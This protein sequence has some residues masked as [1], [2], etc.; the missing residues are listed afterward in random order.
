MRAFLP[1][2]GIDE[3]YSERFACPEHGTFLEEL[4]PRVF[5]FN[6]PYGACAHCCGLGHLQQF[7][8]DLVVP[9]ETLSSI[10]ERRHRALDRARVRRRQGL[11][12]GPP[13]RHRRA[14]RRR[15][16]H[17][18]ARS[19]ARRSGDTVLHGTEDAIEVVYSRGGRETMRFQA[20]FEGVIPNLDRRLREAQ[21]E[22]A[23]EKL[24][25]YMSLVPCPQCHGSRYKPEVL[26]VRVAGRNI[27]DVSNLTVVDARAFFRD[28]TL[29]GAAGDVARPDPARGQRPPRLPRGRRP[30]LPLARPQRQHALRRRGAAHPARDP[31]R[32]RPDGRALRPRRALDRPAP[33]RQRP[34]AADPAR[35]CATS[36]TRSSSSSTTR[37]RCGPRT[38]SWTSARARACTAARWS[39]PAPP[40]ELLA[41]PGLAHRRATCGASCASRCPS[42]DA[43]ATARR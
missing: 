27:A 33:A 13:A 9:D 42:S 29:P 36:A 41:A 28:L 8:P 37:R 31:G 34:P 30:R 15:P 35:T 2:D 26:A 24:E 19:A 39:P 17:P 6:S 21:T 25:S 18:L 5:S 12:L 43:P 32:L 40:A 4:E 16:R 7:D 11:L 3:L 1:D 23:R 22:Y 14:P 20:E 38:T 10:A